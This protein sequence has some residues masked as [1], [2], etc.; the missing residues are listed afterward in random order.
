MP[1]FNIIVVKWL[2]RKHF[3]LVI[4]K[5]WALWG[6]YIMCFQQSDLSLLKPRNKLN[7][8][9][10]QIIHDINK[11]IS[12][13]VYYVFKVMKRSSQSASMNLC[14]LLSINGAWIYHRDVQTINESSGPYS[15]MLLVTS[16]RRF[17]ILFRY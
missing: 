10:P 6:W 4:L 11:T 5:K 13:Y 16:E 15:E 14:K 7:C 9:T 17:S 3:I 1:Y 8:S 12:N 2:M